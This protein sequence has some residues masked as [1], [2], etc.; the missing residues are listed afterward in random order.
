MAVWHDRRAC[1]CSTCCSVGLLLRLS[2]LLVSDTFGKWMR[3][4]C[5]ILLAELAWFRW[6]GE[7]SCSWP[8]LIVSSRR[9]KAYGDVL[10]AINLCVAL[11]TSSVSVL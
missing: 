6:I 9:S 3:A 4:Y 2:S 8:G 11:S 7:M 10:E 5:S 1:M